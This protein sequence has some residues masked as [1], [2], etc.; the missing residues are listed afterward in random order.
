VLPAAPAAPFAVVV[1]WR[2]HP[3]SLWARNRQ[4]FSA[5][6]IATL[7]DHLH[8]RQLAGQRTRHEHH[9]A[10]RQMS[11]CLAAE[12]RADQLDVDFDFGFIRRK[13]QLARRVAS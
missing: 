1:A 7:L 13:A 4:D 2:L 8:A 5:G 9:A 3:T 6:K 11:E 12:R 10:V